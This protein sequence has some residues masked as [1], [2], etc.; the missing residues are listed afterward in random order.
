MKRRIF[1]TAVF[2]CSFV[3]LTVALMC[4]ASA[5][6]VVSGD[7]VYDVNGSVATLKE[8]KGSAAKVTIP[9]KV[10]SATVTAIGNEAFWCVKTMTSV[11]LPSTITSIGNAAFNECTGLTKIVIPSK[12]KSIGDAAFWYCTNLKS[13]VMFK[14]VTKIGNNAFRGCN[15]ALTAYVEKGS[16]AETY[17]KSTD[18]IALA[19]RYID[20]LK[21]DKTAATLQSGATQKLTYT[22]SPSNVY[23]KKASYS[24]SNTKVASVAS[25]GTV[26]AI[27]PGTATITC[28]AGDASGKT[29]TCKITVTPQKVTTFKLTG[30]T[31][32]GYTLSWNKSEGATKY[33][34]YRYNS[35]TKKWDTYKYTSGTSLK[36][37]GLKAGATDYYKVLAYTFVSGTYYKAPTS[38]SFKARPLI[39]AK[40]TNITGKPANNFINLSWN[41]SSNA[42]GYRVYS[43]NTATKKYTA[44]TS[45][46]KTSLKITA[47]NPNTEYTYMVRAYMKV[48]TKTV[49]ADYSEHCTLSTRPD[50]VSGLRVREDSVY[51]SK[52]TLQWDA[53][54]GVDGY[55]LHMYDTESA[56][57]KP[58]ATVEGNINEFTVEDLSAGT[59]YLFKIQALTKDGESILYGYLSKTAVSA[60][61]NSRPTNNKE[62]FAGF[63]EA[64]NASKNSSDSFALINEIFVT[65]FEGENSE[66]YSA[67]VSALAQEHFGILYF[68]EG[69]ERDSKL[70]TTSVL[71]PKDSFCT[72]SEEK[73]AA[74]SLEFTDD[75]NGYRI[76][77]TLPEEANGATNALITEL[78]SFDSFACENEDFT[79][80][81]CTYKGTKVSA[82]IQNGKVDDITIEIPVTV[83]FSIGEATYEFTETV[84]RKNI[85]VW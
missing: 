3:C 28:K 73:L 39:P 55:R 24:S 34:V 74:D 54:E 33:R 43:Y 36:F 37:T 60:T 83:N 29:A 10:N 16:F 17:V 21:L 68:E 11:T 38:A 61:T 35:T 4:C 57:Y 9:S 14:S 1:R 59:E 46:T 19:Y 22:V 41:K 20:T 26:K 23:Y 13:V 85:F 52:I 32:T 50:Y 76:S 58:I 27:A 48:G 80:N 79:L 40:V 12:V 7:F 53:L 2:I 15:S 49:W 42:T 67:V 25:D 45:T 62:A 63:I 30:V 8:Y 71:A 69:I 51:V 66:Q 82:K 47:L 81:S 44:L 6:Y 75:G 77:F 56:A 84:T 31:S 72:L 18:G 5:K 78:F 64:Y 65:D 70:P